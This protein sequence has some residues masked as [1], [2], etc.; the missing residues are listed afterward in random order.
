MDYIY[1]NIIPLFIFNLGNF[2]NIHHDLILI[3]N[4]KFFIN[5]YKNLIDLI[6]DSLKFNLFYN[7]EFNLNIYHQVINLK[8]DL[9]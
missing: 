6:D 8:L 5:H 4:F 2:I 1:L 7:I 3:F 9:I